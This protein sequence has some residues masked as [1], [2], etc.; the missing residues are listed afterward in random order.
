MTA[1]EHYKFRILMLDRLYL[2]Q[3]R[4]DTLLKDN[5][6]SILTHIVNSININVE[7]SNLTKCENI[8]SFSNN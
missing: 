7:I 1:E 6:I 4:L 8:N 2:L 5:Q 3:E